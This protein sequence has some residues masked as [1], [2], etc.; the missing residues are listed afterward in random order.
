MG[1]ER[2]VLLARHWLPP[3]ISF[4]L[5]GT[6]GHHFNGFGQAGAQAGS[7]AEEGGPR[8]SLHHSATGFSSWRTILG[9]GGLVALLAFLY[10]SVSCSDLYPGPVP[11]NPN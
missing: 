10:T 4:R 3:S 6:P 5:L 9:P 7:A 8:V 2:E 1:Q 11:Q